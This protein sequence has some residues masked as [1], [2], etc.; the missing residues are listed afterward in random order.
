VDAA[1]ITPFSVDASAVELP[2][3]SASPFAQAPPSAFRRAPD[4]AFEP[5][6]QL[7]TRGPRLQCVPFARNEAGVQIFGDA[8]TWWAQAAGRYVRA[9]RPAERS[10]MVMRGY[11]DPNRG[12]VA[13]VR[14]I[15]SERMVL[16]DHANWL[17][18]GEITRAV[19]VR[20]V[21]PEGDW[22]Q[23]QVWNVVGRHWGGRTYRVRGFILPQEAETQIAANPI[24]PE[25]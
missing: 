10:V 6:A 14:D 18:R 24:G 4:E 2:P 16:V 5:N 7:S 23:V 19:P 22:S 8:V 13:V 20:D 25:A 17:N 9:P 21:S 1:A 12:H 15:V 3:P 11:A